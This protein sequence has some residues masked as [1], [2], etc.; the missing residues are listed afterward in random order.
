MGMNVLSVDLD[1]QGSL[2]QGFLGPPTVEQLT[3]AETVTALFDDE[4]FFSERSAMLRPTGFDA[5]TICPANQTLAPFNTPSPEST[6]LKQYMVDEFLREF[7]SEY[8][9]VLLDCPPN[10]YRCSWSAMLAADFVII[11]V[12]PEDF[13]TQGLRAV[14]QSIE[15][16]RK[17]N[18][19]LRRL[20][21]LIT[22]SDRR[23]IIHRS[24]EGR[25][26]EL[27]D[28]MVLE[29]VVPEASAFKVSLACRQPVEFFGPKTAAAVTMRSLGQEIVEK[30]ND[31]SARRR[32]A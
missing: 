11:P 12:P 18:P 14:H 1:P 30:I 8:D 6:G 2:S 9:I 4:H 31:K 20:G 7:A 15:Q 21:H 3:S 17:L 32:V 22:R 26:R 25:L 24:Y 10:L 16:A 5:M 28:N 19:R 29:T 27:Y 13:G 23:L